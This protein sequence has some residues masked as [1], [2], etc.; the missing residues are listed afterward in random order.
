MNV[1]TSEI[2]YQIPGMG[3][4]MS[5]MRLVV[6][7]IVAVVAAVG[8]HPARDSSETWTTWSSADTATT[9]SSTSP[10]PTA[11]PP[12]TLP[13]RAEPELP[14]TYVDTRYV[15]PSGRRVMVR[16]G[17]NL[18]AALD[19]A[20]SGD[21]LLLEPSAT[22]VGN[23]TLPEKAGA[24]WITIRSAAPEAQLPPEGTRITPA[25]G[26]VM[27]KIVSPNGDAAVQTAMRAHNYRI[28]GVEITVAPGVMRNHG[29]VTL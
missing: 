22:F 4:R 20:Q 17:E 23:F 29:I 8:C 18:Q 2:G 24:G 16:R 7:G 28:I 1:R 3:Y 6:V 26:A 19:A 15:A 11:A 9:D 12:R 10:A 14:R 27:P 25:F 21:V 13:P 5:D